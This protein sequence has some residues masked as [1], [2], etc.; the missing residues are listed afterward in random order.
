MIELL[1]DYGRVTGQIQQ[2]AGTTINIQNNVQILNSAPFADLQAGLLQICAEHPETRGAIV[3]LFH[4]L[5]E[6]YATPGRQLIE[7]REAVH[8]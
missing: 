1:R 6:K 2:F 3:A 7:A 4:D 5:D 8:A